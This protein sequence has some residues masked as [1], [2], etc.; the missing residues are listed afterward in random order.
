MREIESWD[1]VDDIFTEGG[2]SGY[3]WQT[4][5]LIAF[6]LSDGTRVYAHYADG[7]CSCTAPRLSPIK[8]Q[9]L[10]WTT[11]LD[12]VYRAVRE[13]VRSLSMDAGNRT[14]ALSRLAS[15]VRRERAR[16]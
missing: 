16:K 8:S 11:D 9:D 10:S 3:D 13:G 6:T 12:S 5:E 7:G 14:R 4:E 15:A 2:G 1:Q